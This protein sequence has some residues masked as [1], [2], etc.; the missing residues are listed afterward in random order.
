MAKG[1]TEPEGLSPKLT[2]RLQLH[3]IENRHRIENEVLL[4]RQAVRKALHNKDKSREAAKPQFGQ[5]PQSTTG[6]RAPQDETDTG[7]VPTTSEAP[8][9]MDT[10]AEDEFKRGSRWFFKRDTSKS[11]SSTPRDGREVEPRNARRANG[12]A[13]PTWRGS[14]PSFFQAQEAFHLQTVP[15]PTVAEPAH[16]PAETVLQNVIPPPS[17]SLF[18]RIR[19]KSVISSPFSTL[20]HTAA[21][22]TSRPG[23]EYG[24]RDDQGSWSSDTSSDGELP[25]PEWRGSRNQQFPS[26]VNFEDVDDILIHSSPDDEADGNGH[27]GLD[28]VADGVDPDS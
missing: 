28:G 26:L 11:G 4:G 10:D 17:P 25:S 18:N 1:G 3:M 5:F 23:S 27:V 13:S 22:V 7:P 15:Q 12:V 8:M 16:L 2:N 20:R 21:K 6:P 24:A 19:R 14:W 9:S